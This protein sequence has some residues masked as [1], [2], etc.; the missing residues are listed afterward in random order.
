MTVENGQRVRCAGLV[1][2]RQQPGTAS[3]VT[4]MTLEDETGFIN[5][6]VWI[7]VFER[8]A[9][10]VHTENFVAVSGRVPRKGVVVH[11]LAEKRWS[12]RVQVE[13]VEVGSRNLRCSLRTADTPRTARNCEAPG[14]VPLRSRNHEPTYCRHG[15]RDDDLSAPRATLAAPAKIDASPLDS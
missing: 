2:C 15:G 8:F 3:E 6:A 9:L 4:F 5:V 11:V 10:V 13:P 7:P 14:A 1:I 12:P